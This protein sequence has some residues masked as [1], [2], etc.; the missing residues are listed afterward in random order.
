[1]RA[2]CTGSL[3]GFRSSRDIPVAPSRAGFVEASW[4]PQSP[5]FDRP[6]PAGRADVIGLDPDSTR[7]RPHT[8][9]PC[10]QGVTGSSP[11]SGLV[12]VARQRRFG[13]SLF[14]PP[15]GLA[16]VRARFGR[17]A[18][19]SRRSGWEPKFGEELRF[20][21]CTTSL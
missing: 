10:K 15:F 20:A 8:L 6:R 19:A 2:P 5:G 9:A 13:L 14:D 1:M 3:L 16:S 4:K 18:L 11:V 17:L 21:F 12:G 7:S